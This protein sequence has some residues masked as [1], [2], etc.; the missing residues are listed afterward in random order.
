MRVYPR[1]PSKSPT[2]PTESTEQYERAERAEPNTFAPRTMKCIA[3]LGAAVLALAVRNAESFFLPA[4]NVVGGGATAVSPAL[5]ASSVSSCN[6]SIVARAAPRGSGCSC[7]SCNGGTYG[8]SCRCPSCSKG[9]SARSHA[10]GCRCGACLVRMQ[11]HP[12][13]C[14]CGDCTPAPA[15]FHGSCCSCADCSYLSKAEPCACSICASRSGGRGASSATVMRM[16]AGQVSDAGEGLRARLVEEPGSVMFEEAMG[17]V[18]AGF[19]YTP[20]R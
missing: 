1:G 9:L 4:G 17:A 16:G 11:A 19:D 2:E 12:V 18:E 14:G 7:P 15:A 8:R 13:G 3:V 6:S 20:K 10:V 5:T